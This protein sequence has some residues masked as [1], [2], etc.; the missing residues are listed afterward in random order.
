MTEE[1]SGKQCG[2]RNEVKL[3]WVHRDI[4]DSETKKSRENEINDQ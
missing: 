2:L 1:G 3:T 4:S